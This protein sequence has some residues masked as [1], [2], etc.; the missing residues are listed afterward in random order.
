MLLQW[1]QLLVEFVMF[2][3]KI[4][5]RKLTMQYFHLKYLLI[6][7]LVCQSMLHIQ[8]KYL[9]FAFKVERQE[10]LILCRKVK[11][12]YYRNFQVGLVQ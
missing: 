2:Q 6:L 3:S 10:P 12:S 4:V 5:D 7:C 8:E 9:K 11:Q 1:L